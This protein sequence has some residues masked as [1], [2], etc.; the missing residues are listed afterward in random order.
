MAWP[1]VVSTSGGSTLSHGEN[2]WTQRGR[3]GHPLTASAAP[4]SSS[5]GSGSFACKPRKRSEECLR[6]RVTGLLERHAGGQRLDDPAAEHDG[7]GRRDATHDMEVMTDEDHREGKLLPQVEEEIQDL[8]LD[9][10]VERAQ[11]L[12]GDQDVRGGGQ[13]ARDADP[14]P[15]AP[16]ELRGEPLCGS[17]P[18]IRPGRGAHRLAQDVARRGRA[19]ARGEPPPVPTRRRCVG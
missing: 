13:R 3:N 12:I 1:G 4:R 2:A 17:E 18:A 5:P 14:L 8:S 6:V 15:L 11:R 7:D 16:G 10:Y 9:R 19:C